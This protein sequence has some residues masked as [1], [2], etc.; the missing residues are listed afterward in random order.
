VGNFF[1][2][3]SPRKP[4]PLPDEQ[5]SSSANT[6]FDFPRV[7]RLPKTLILFWARFRPLS[8]TSTAPTNCYA[9][10]ERMSGIAGSWPD[11]SDK[12]LRPRLPP[13]EVIH[14]FQAFVFPLLFPVTVRK[15]A[16]LIPVVLPAA[17]DFDLCPSALFL[18]E[19]LFN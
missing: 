8:H 3:A 4:P 18:I 2:C 7:P 19:E 10:Y 9:S 15:Y 16:Q 1:R 14:V 11:P 17:S 13:S 6:L 12:A 5:Y